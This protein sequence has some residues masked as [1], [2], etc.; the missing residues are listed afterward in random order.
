VVD[1]SLDYNLLLG[2]SWTYAMQAVVT[3]V[4]WVLLF[5]HEGQIMSIDQ[6][7]FS[8]PDPSSGV[9]TVPMID[10]PQPDIINIGVGLC[11]PLMGT[12][13]YPPPTDNVHY[14]SVVPDQP[15]A[16]I[17]QISSFRM[18]YFNDPWT[19][20]SPSATMEGTGHH[21]MA[22]PLS[23]TEVAYS[24]VQ[25]ASADPDPTP[26]QELD[27]VLEPTWAQGSLTDTDSLDLVFPS[28][29]VI[30]EA[31]TS[32]DRPWDDLHHR[33]YFLPELR[34]I[35]AGEFTLTMTGDKACPINP[36]AMHIVY[37]EGNMETIAQM[38][39]IDISRIPGIME[40]IF[41]GADCSPEEIQI[42]TDLFK[43]FA[44]CFPGLTRKCQA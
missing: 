39:P 30:I 44:T 5:P 29:E 33:S 4:F 23:M 22:M 43:E 19:L 24:I 10:N 21:G 28:D 25:Q 31:M 9:S 42:Y 7:S 20:P 37:T 8:H 11:P 40:N 12:F 27:P 34:R 32:P 13:D 36:L 17:F 2:R 3:T 18:T 35:E 16:E 14:I 6:L 26:A 38:I 15:R 41:I 1:A